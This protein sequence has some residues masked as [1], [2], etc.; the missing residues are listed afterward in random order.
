MNIVH[1]HYNSPTNFNVG[2]EAHVL[3]IQDMLHTLG[4][5]IN[6]INIPI[7]V[8]CKTQVPP[9]I[10]GYRR[11][12]DRVQNLAR[13]FGNG[14]LKEILD[15]VNSSDLVVIGGGGVYMNHLL[16]FNNSLINKIKP[17]IVLYGVGY[18]RNFNDVEFSAE[19]KASIIALGQKASLQ[20]VRD[21]N[22]KEFLETLGV[23]S[24]LLCDPAV[25]LET[26]DRQYSS[27]TTK[28]LKVGL[29][30]AAHGW[31]EQDKQLPRIIQE[32][33]D[34]AKKLSKN[35]KEDVSFLYFVHYP[36]EIEVANLLRDMG[37]SLKIVE[38]NSRE[39]LAAYSTVRFTVSMM[40]HSTILAFAAGRPAISI[41]YDEKNLSFMELTGQN[42]HFV[43]VYNA[44]ADIIYEKAMQLLQD[45]EKIGLELVARKAQFK[46]A[47]KKF[48]ERTKRLV[49]YR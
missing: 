7:N 23:K 34:F 8:L 41:G 17:P 39:L 38:G 1:I 44:N 48:L 9:Y 21:I 14:S 20:T 18:N 31:K 35:N 40:L 19:K 29:N 49:T 45:Y 26:K 22:T 2:D 24:D 43:D 28:S 32:Y 25:F 4:D 47:N 36:A 6:V 46:R 27:D 13:Y 30:I 33:A 12:P 15:R 10:P 5:D 42:S 16:P 11:F 3:A 37:V